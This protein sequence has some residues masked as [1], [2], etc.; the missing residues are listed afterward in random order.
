M[1]GPYMGGAGACAPAPTGDSNK[2]AAAAAAINLIMTFLS[3]MHRLSGSGPGNM[4][5][6]EAGWTGPDAVTLRCSEFQ[7]RQ[8]RLQRRELLVV[9][10][11]YRGLDFL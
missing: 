6:G 11:L 3:R 10:T 8:L 4:R 9:L 5:E 7:A 1:G 2:A